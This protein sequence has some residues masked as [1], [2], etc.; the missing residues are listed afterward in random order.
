MAYLQYKEINKIDTATLPIALQVVKEYMVVDYND[1]DTLITSLIWSTI[2]YIE[3][4][5]C[6]VLVKANCKAIYHQS[7]GDVVKLAYCDNISM[8]LDSP[9]QV[10]GDMIHTTDDIV[11]IEYVAGY[12]VGVLP[13]WAQQAIKMNVSWR[14]S[15]RGD[16]AID[17]NQIDNE[18]KEFLKPYVNWRML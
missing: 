17:I 7:G 16:V 3:E 10:V 2:H 4:Y 15:N 13:E 18:T 14:Y 5:T 6:R 12:N 8:P 9:Y 1:H 11:S